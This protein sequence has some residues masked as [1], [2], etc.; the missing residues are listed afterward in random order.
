[1]YQIV[2]IGAGQ[3]G[4]TYA[5]YAHES[6][7]ARVVAVAELDAERRAKAARELEIPPERC[8]DDADALLDAGKL[9]DAAII[10]TMDRSHYAEAMRALALGYD[11]LLEKPISPSA[12]ECLRIAEEARR[13]KRRVTVCHVLRYTPFFTKIKE[14]VDSRE[15]G[16]IVAIEHTENIGN[17]HMAHS[18]VRGNWGNSDRSSPIIMQK[19]CHDMDILYWLIGSPCASVASVGELTYFRPENA[20]AGSAEHCIDCAVAADCRFEARRVYWADAGR[21]PSTM[22]C[23]D[24]TAEAIEQALRTSPYGR[25]VY[26]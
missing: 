13:R 23:V 24:Q 25:C 1:M 15:L 6:G 26:R 12:T 5:K 2:L 14:I 21:W 9:G 19:S 7:L 10:A 17:L 22:V 4:C 11:L 8:Y 16:R 3:R 18:F 20:P